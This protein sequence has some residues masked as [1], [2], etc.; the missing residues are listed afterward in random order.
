M[1][2]CVT[3]VR[4]I[5]GSKHEFVIK[6]LKMLI[7]ANLCY[8]AEEIVLMNMIKTEVYS[9]KKVATYYSIDAAAFFLFNVAHWMFAHKYFS[10]ARQTPF[11]LDNKEVPKSIVKSDKIINWVFLCLNSVPPTFYGAGIIGF[12][13]A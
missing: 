5:R 9:N 11:K 12:F 6:I 1:I 8:Y 3:L 4:V 13:V 7:G 10:M 2:E